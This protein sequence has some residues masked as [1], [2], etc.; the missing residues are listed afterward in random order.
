MHIWVDGMTNL[1]LLTKMGCHYI[2]AKNPAADEEHNCGKNN[3]VGKFDQ[4]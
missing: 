4:I 3:P 2:C 1:R